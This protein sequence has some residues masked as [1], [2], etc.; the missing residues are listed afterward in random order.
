MQNPAIYASQGLSNGGFSDYNS[1]QLELRRQYRSGFLGQINYT[2]S[3]TQ[4][5][6][7]RARRR[8]GSRHSWTTSGR[9]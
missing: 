4:D 2:L 7:G 8:T 1:L 9:S 3:N 5:R 6:L